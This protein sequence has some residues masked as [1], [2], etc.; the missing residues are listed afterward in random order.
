MVDT[1][2]DLNFEKAGPPMKAV[3]LE[4]LGEMIKNSIGAIKALDKKG[5]A[6]SE[7]AEPIVDNLILLFLARGRT[8][9]SAADW[10][11][12]LDGLVEVMDPDGWHRDE[13]YD[14]EWNKELIAFEEFMQ[15]AAMSTCRMSRNF[16]LHYGMSRLSEERKT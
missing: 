6:P 13:R 3:F 14:Y 9:R 5:V 11:T 1:S 15:K 12:A 10:Q 2:K 7:V 8:K 16:T 4:T